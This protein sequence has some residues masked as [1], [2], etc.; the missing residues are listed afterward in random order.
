MFRML[1]SKAIGDDHCGVSPEAII[2]GRNPSPK[3][4]CHTKCRHQTAG[5]ACSR[6]AHGFRV[7]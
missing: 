4:R 3:L 2:I 5:D 6:N 7:A 1:A